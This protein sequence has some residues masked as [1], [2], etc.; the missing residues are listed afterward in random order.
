MQQSNNFR[1]G[2]LESLGVKNLQE[3]QEKRS[4]RGQKTQGS[5]SFLK[6]IRNWVDE[7]L[8]IVL[9]GAFF[10]NTGET[11][12]GFPPHVETD[13]VGYGNLD[14]GIGDGVNQNIGYNGCD[15]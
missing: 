11:Q 15:H 4:S 10:Q 5:L 2:F 1:L 7:F 14:D 6:H 9:I 12:D 8:H 13:L 3:G